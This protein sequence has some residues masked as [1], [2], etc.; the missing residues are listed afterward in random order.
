MFVGEY[1]HTI[2]HKGRISVPSKFRGKLAE[3][4][5]ITRGLDFSLFIYT[6]YEWQKLAKKLS[7]LPISQ[8]DARAFVRLMFSGASEVEL[9]KQGR[10]IIP[11]YLREYAK[12]NADVVICGL[13][14]RI[15][16]WD[17]EKWDLYKKESEK[18]ST[19]IAE[20]LGNLGV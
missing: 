3:G 6:K 17:K 12:L 15:E 18:D 10:I 4:C 7:E 16:I 20:H 13:F 9:D 1:R 11:I 5:V 14:D 2:D 19:D 8:S